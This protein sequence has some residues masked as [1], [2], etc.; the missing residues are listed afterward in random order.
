MLG[1]LWHTTSAAWPLLPLRSRDG[2]VGLR[3]AKA[4]AGEVSVAC[5]LILPRQGPLALFMPFAGFKCQWRLA[6]GQLCVG[7]GVGRAR[8]RRQRCGGGVGVGGGGVGGSGCGGC[9]GGGPVGRPGVGLGATWRIV[10]E[11]AARVVPVV[12]GAVVGARAGSW[13][14]RLRW[15][16]WWRKLLADAVAEE[17]VT[18]VAVVA[19]F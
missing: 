6:V 9:V 16:L 14:W 3:L 19:G 13:E 5:R 11:V 12:A 4:A 10:V 15:C 18:S 1:F 7:G 2:R 8:G 17:A